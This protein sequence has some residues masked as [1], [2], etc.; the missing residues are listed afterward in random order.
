MLALARWVWLS[1]EHGGHSTDL[2]FM[3]FSLKWAPFGSLRWASAV[4]PVQV[5]ASKFEL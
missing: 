5:H 4:L 3:S 1:T 2:Q